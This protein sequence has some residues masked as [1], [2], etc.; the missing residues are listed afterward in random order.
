MNKTTKRHSIIGIFIAVAIAFG[1][2]YAFAD[3]ADLHSPTLGAGSTSISSCQPA[4][5][6][7]SYG[8]HLL[9]ERPFMRVARRAPVAEPAIP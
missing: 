3:G 8:F 1:T 4:P 9:F 2:T 5:V 7:V 6:A